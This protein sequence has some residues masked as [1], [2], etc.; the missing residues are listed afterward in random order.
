MYA[1]ELQKLNDAV[2]SLLHQQSTSETIERLRLEIS[3]SP[4]PFVWSV[5]S[6][7]SIQREL[8]ESIKS[9]WVFVLKPDVPSGCHYHPNSIQHMVVL[10]GKGQSQI[11]GVRKEMVR[12]GQPELS[13]AD[14]WYVID[15]DVPHEFFPEEE[16]MVVVSFH[17]CKATQ[18]VEIECSTGKSR[19][20]EEAIQE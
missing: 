14:T 5:I 8:P 15:K 16:Q 11:A 6:T 19:H 7:D 2:E 17:T 12:Y 3:R 10:E 9:C 20:Y 18:L 4:E 1:A 13:L